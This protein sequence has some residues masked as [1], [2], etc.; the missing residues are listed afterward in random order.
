MDVDDTAVDDDATAGQ[1]TDTGTDGSSGL[2]LAVLTAGAVQATPTEKT[3]KKGDSK[4]KKQLAA[5]A[6]AAKAKEAAAT[7]T[8]L[9]STYSSVVRAIATSDVACG[10]ESVKPL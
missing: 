5:L 7:T 8:R 2:P 9:R 4:K 6:V 3:K 10:R 1:P